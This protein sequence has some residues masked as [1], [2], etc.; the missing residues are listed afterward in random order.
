MEAGRFAAVNKNSESRGGGDEASQKPFDAENS[1]NV[2]ECYCDVFCMLHMLDWCEARE[3]CRRSESQR[4]PLMV[5]AIV[6]A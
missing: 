4:T 2:S 3:K 6:C 1:K 5:A